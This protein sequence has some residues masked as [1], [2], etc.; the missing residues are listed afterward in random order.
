LD[1]IKDITWLRPDGKEMGEIDWHTDFVRAVEILL[2]G[3]DLRE[4]DE[5]G[6]PVSDSLFLILLNAHHAAIP[7]RLP[8]LPS[9]GNW[10]TRLD[11][12]KGWLTPSGP[13]PDVHPP[14]AE[15]LLADRALALFEW[16]PEE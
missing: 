9:S 6:R 10:H 11:T 12:V 4:V 1:R 2:D 15:Y 8:A 13:S 3:K 16:V 7:F 5:R 14:G